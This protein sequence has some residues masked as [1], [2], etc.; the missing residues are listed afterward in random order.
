M[1]ISLYH[2]IICD[3]KACYPIRD[4]PSEHNH[5]KMTDI[6]RYSKEN[7]GNKFTEDETTELR[8]IFN[9]GITHADCNFCEEAY[10]PRR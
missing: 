6:T 1:N 5:L 7:F 10:H 4:R 3:I 8:R 2:N 9:G